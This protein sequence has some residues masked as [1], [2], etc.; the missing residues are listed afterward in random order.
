MFGTV[1]AAAPSVL[2]AP[3]VSGPA[4][5]ARGV[6]GGA[7]GGVA[8]ATEFSPT[9]SALERG[10]NALVGAATGAMWHRWQERSAIK[11]AICIARWRVGPREQERLHN[12]L[13]SM[14]LFNKC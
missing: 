6:A 8:G 4:W 13:R 11:Q 3:Q 5:L 2:V 7:A 9:N 12:P 10:K 14:T 1:A